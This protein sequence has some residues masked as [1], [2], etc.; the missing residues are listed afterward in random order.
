M[1]VFQLLGPLDL[2]AADGRALQSVLSGP[3]RVALLAY[4]AVHGPG[5]FH[6]RD[7][8]LGLFWPESDQERA[9]GS[10]RSALHVLR[11]ALGDG[12]II[13]RGDEEIGLAE[14]VLRCDAADVRSALREGRAEEAVRLYSGELL[15]GFFLSDSPEFERWL[16][17]ERRRLR[18]E[19]TDAAWSL[20]AAARQSGRP[21]AIE[22]ARR[23][24]TL[25]G[26]EAALRR[27][28]EVLAWAD[29]RAGALREYE[30][31]AARMHLDDGPEPGP[32]TRALAAEIGRP[33][34]STPPPSA[35]LPVQ[36]EAPE[37]TR[38]VSPSRAAPPAK[39][40]D[41]DR[42]V[43]PLLP[44]A[45]A[46][47]FQP[48][49]RSLRA[50]A[51]LALVLMAGG[52]L[53]RAQRPA[54][55]P[56]SSGTVAV[57]PFMVRGDSS[58][59]VLGEGMVPLL[60]GKLDGVGDLHTVDS[61]T[62]LSSLELRG[63]E[64]VGEAEARAVAERF[65]AEMYILGTI[66]QVGSRYQIAATLFKDDETPRAVARAQVETERERFF[67]AVDRLAAGLVAGRGTGQSPASFVQAISD[68]THSLTAL[69]AYLQGESAYRQGRFAEAV[70]WLQRATD[71]DSTFALADYRLAVAA[72]WADQPI[73]SSAAANRALRNASRLPEHDRRLLEAYVAYLARDMH[74]AER[75]YR[76]IT[77]DYPSDVEAWA[78]LGEVRFHF[79][80]VAGRSLHAAR[81]AWERVLALNPAH[82]D[83]LVHLARLA[84]RD[85]LSA[86]V[87]SLVHRYQQHAGSSDHLLEML[88]LRAY[89]TGSAETQAEVLRDL[90]LAPDLVLLS[91]V[92][93]LGF[94]R[95]L[96]GAL[97]V[98]RLLTAPERPGRARGLSLV[99]SL[100]M[101]VGRPATARAMSRAVAAEFGTARLPLDLA[102]LA[103]HPD[104]LAS[105]AERM[106][107]LEGLAAG[108]G[109]LGGDTLSPEIRLQQDVARLFL[110]AQLH[111]QLGRAS[112]T[113]RIAKA[114]EAAA[115]RRG[116]ETMRVAGDLAAG[117]R[118]QAALT[119]GR[120]DQAVQHHRRVQRRGH[121]T[122]MLHTVH[123]TQFI[124]AERFALAEA[125]RAAGKHAEA[126][127]VYQS[128]PE[129]SGDDLSYVGMALL[130]EGEL[131]E[132][133]GDRARA[134]RAYSRLL[135]IWSAPEPTL[136]ST[137]ADVRARVER[138]SRRAG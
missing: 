20:C 28:M 137:V 26:D 115:G 120:P 47:L 60:S 2:R 51:V 49:Q 57:L 69:G 128:F 90:R 130:R 82:A 38:V 104:P 83:A 17:D 117:L 54:S 14:G 112:E 95:E 4:L 79:D 107:A 58:A 110:T 31:F 105:N 19:V 66:L 24:F 37:P 27:L 116:P 48:G 59:R 72:E 56:V 88:A 111:N 109:L 29:D 23:G 97:Q 36:A 87:D 52:A 127:T 96:P 18:R 55:P 91:T 123:L 41:P 94:A 1:I 5:R 85:G 11:R 15:E 16:D 93:A 64:A 135:R 70:Q 75:A 125:L 43:A 30:D 76:A 8:L 53:W 22:W 34:A 77:R 35:P 39:N 118:A 84:A 138:L 100:E 9:R 6:R 103:A 67:E 106:H 102:A 44:P 113:E 86:R 50:V 46:P 45:R 21:E 12:V 10:L 134:L 81:Y 89:A 13:S 33:A 131:H 7:V 129:P 136:R 121:G 119:S 25:S 132:R 32:E 63:A 73:L 122:P 40:P 80:P 114:I 101:A 133:L 71:V 124:G 126:L 61:Y 62:L 65:G 98:A 68:G 3:K 92:Q 78:Q 108:A 99:R 74:E 42:R